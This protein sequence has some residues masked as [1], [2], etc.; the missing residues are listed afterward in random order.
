MNK[1]KLKNE[2][3]ELVKSFLI[4]LVICFFLIKF[5]MMSVVVDGTSMLPNLHDGDFGFSFVIARNI[6]INRFDTV[7]INASNDKKIVKR[8]I[9]LPG[10]TVEYIDNELYI[11]GMLTYQNF[12]YQ[13]STQNLRVTLGENEY[14]VLGDNRENSKDSRYY[15]PFTKDKIVSSHVL[16]LFPFTDFGFDR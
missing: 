10:E 3:I 15:G 5:V 8:V 13:G 12:E 4:A 9:G 1:E 14:F 2:L 16:V 7:V 11:D 6:S